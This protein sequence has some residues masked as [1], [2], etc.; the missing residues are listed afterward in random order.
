MKEEEKKELQKKE[1]NETIKK[2]GCVSKLPP[3]QI[4]R[5]C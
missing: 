5:M 1:S 3:K 2:Q 4:S